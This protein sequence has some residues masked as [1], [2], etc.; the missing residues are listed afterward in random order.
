[1]AEGKAKKPIFKKWWFWVIIAVFVIGIAAN[2]GKD[3]SKETVTPA[4]SPDASASGSAATA[5][6]ADSAAPSAKATEAP[7]NKPT[8]S[9]AEFDKLESG[10]TYDEAT[11]IIGGPGE[12][13]S[14]SGKKGGTD[15]EIHTVMLQY[16][17]EG[18]VGANANLM[19]QDEKLVNKAQMG[20][21]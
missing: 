16:K 8:M 14:E 1:M 3:D 18:G 10:M 17:G 5:K 11:A 7:K 2:A 9:K 20:L 19:F 4:T 21:K 12:V 13:V 15:L 6:P